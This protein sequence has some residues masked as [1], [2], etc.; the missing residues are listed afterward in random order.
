MGYYGASGM[1]YYG[2]SMMVYYGL[3]VYGN[4]DQ[5]AIQPAM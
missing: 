1:S 2:M 3:M 5:V 4:Y